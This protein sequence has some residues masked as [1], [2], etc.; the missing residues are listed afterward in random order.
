MRATY[1]RAYALSLPQ[2]MLPVGG[3]WTAQFHFNILKAGT[4][5]V[6]SSFTGTV[7]LADGIVFTLQTAGPAAGA[8]TGSGGGNLGYFGLKPSFGVRFDTWCNGCPFNPVY[9]ADHSTFG[10]MTNGNVTN[11]ALSNDATPA[12]IQWWEP[13][14]FDVTV[15]YDAIAMIVTTTAFMTWDMERYVTWVTPVNLTSVLQC[16]GQDINCQAY[17]GFTAATGGSASQQQITSFSF[18]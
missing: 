11:D 1:L 9:G 4:W 16:P 3:S 13:G 6:K 2:Q 15:S 18:T 5:A 10:Y 12:G 17:V 7:K 8:T 14:G